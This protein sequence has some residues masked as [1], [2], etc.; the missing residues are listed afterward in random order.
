MTDILLPATSA[1]DWRKHLADPIKHWA[2]GYS[3]KTLAYCWQEAGGFPHSVTTVFQKAGPP[4]ADLEPLLILPEHKVPLPGG[5]AASQNDIWVL[6]RTG[7]ELVSVAVEGKVNEPFDK[8]VAEWF[9]H[10]SEGKN[11]RFTYLTETLGVDIPRTSAVRYQLLHRTASA[12]IE[13]GRFRADHAM[14]LIHSFS[15]THAWFEDFAAFVALWGITAERNQVY[16]TRLPSGCALH[17]AWVHG[18]AQYLSK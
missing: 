5:K 9:E 14:V 2:T 7:S 11:T 8:T 13:A 17:F 1:E 4:F 10:D 12:V 15:P 16:S 18:E 3:A 6:A